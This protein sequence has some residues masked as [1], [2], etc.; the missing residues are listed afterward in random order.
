[1][2]TDAYTALRDFLAAIPAGPR[3][4]RRRER[5]T[6]CAI[7]GVQPTT[8]VDVCPACGGYAQPMPNIAL[9]RRVKVA[10]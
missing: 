10:A 5:D 9:T 3:V 1:M 6:L 2:R 7:H 8:N 4:N